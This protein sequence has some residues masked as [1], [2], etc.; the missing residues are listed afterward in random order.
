MT[1]IT[2]CLKWCIAGARVLVACSKCG[3]N[4]LVDDTFC[5]ACGA[6]R[7]YWLELLRTGIWHQVRA[8]ARLILEGGLLQDRTLNGL[9]ILG[10]A[11]AWFTLF[12]ALR[13]RIN[14]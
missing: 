6:R 7:W 1:S 12:F 2:A 13:K 3:S 8:A 11:G 10:V 9:A 5:N 4:V 14:K